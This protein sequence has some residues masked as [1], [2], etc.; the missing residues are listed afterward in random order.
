MTFVSSSSRSRRNGCGQVASENRSEMLSAMLE[1]LE[2]GEFADRWEAAK[3]LPSFGRSALEGI[4]ELLRSHPDDA[5]LGWFAAQAIAQFDDSAAIATLVNWVTTASVDEDVRAMAAR[6]LATLGEPAIAPLSELLREK[7]W[8][9]LA[10]RT[11]AQVRH[12]GAIE[13]LFPLW[14]EGNREVRAEIL[15]VLA[16]RR[17]RRA[18]P[19]ILQGLKDLGARVR[20]EATIA[21]GLYGDFAPEVDAVALLEAQLLD[22]DLSVAQQAAIALSRIGTPTGISVLARMLRSAH[23]PPPLQFHLIRALGWIEH[24]EAIEGLLSA[25]SVPHEGLC[26]ETIRILCQIRDP[27]LTPQVVQ[28]L[29]NWWYANPPQRESPHIRQAIALGLGNFNQRESQAIVRS[30]LEDPDEAVR[31]HARAGT[32]QS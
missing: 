11:L 4:L 8:Q 7:P 3:R 17:D 2:W 28:G 5:E 16:T 15:A 6:G 19:L 30:L 27:L 9:V 23:T 18:I 20:R 10:I 13:P 26:A 32:K 29:V 21:L 24:P 31:W 22:L 12:P 25:L 14:D 1:V